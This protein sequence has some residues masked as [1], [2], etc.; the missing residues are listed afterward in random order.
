MQIIDCLAITAV[1]CFFVL[2]TEMPSKAQ[3]NSIY[4][5]LAGWDFPHWVYLTILPLPTHAYAPGRQSLWIMDKDTDAQSP[6]LSPGLLRILLLLS[7]TELL[8]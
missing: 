7:T 3:S 8:Q 4:N 6:Q 5:T 1:Q 2:L